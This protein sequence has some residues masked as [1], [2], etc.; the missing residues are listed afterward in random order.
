MIFIYKT[1]LM[2][3]LSIKGQT[4]YSVCVLGCAN[5][6]LDGFLGS[7]C[8]FIDYCRI[9]ALLPVIPLGIMNNW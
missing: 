6:D 9:V 2:N 1:D 4:D 3:C 7:L 5:K 8:K